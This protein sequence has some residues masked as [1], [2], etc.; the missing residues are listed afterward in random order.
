[1]SLGRTGRSK[2]LKRRSVARPDAPLL[3]VG[4]RLRVAIVLGAFENQAS[5]VAALGFSRA[6]VM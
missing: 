5:L 1:M 3:A 4:H 6:R 2:R